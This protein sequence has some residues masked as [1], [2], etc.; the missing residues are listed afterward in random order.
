M[1][2]TGQKILLIDPETARI[3]SL[4]DVLNGSPLPGLRITTCLNLQD[5]RARLQEQS[6]A[7]IIVRFPV[8]DDS[9]AE[10]AELSALLALHESKPVIGLMEQSDTAGVFAALRLGIADLFVVSQVVSEQQAFIRS[11]TR[12]LAQARMIEENRFYRE[13][14]AQ[15]LSELK[16]DQQ[17]AYHVQRSMMPAE[18]IEVC[19][20]KARYLLMPSLYLSGDFVDV[21][22]VDE[23]RAVFYLADVSG[24]G[25]SSALVT[26]LLKNIARSMV[27][28]Y[29]LNPDTGPD[30]LTD[31]LERINK[32]LLET[33]VGKHLSI[34]IG[35]IDTEKLR[36]SYAVGGHH[37][38]PL[39]TDSA[40][41]RFLE[42]RGMPVGLFEKPV[43][44]ERTIELEPGFQVTLF[45]D[46]ILEVLPQKNM[47]SREEY[48]RGVVNNLRGATPE[49]LRDVLLSGFQS[50]VPD[51][52][53]VMTI[54]GL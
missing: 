37:P 46:G 8:N 40:G 50:E 20:I 16:A 2:R 5:A 51:D 26:M 43:Y 21:V 31:V 15:S 30:S 27:R 14:L 39:L 12:L 33:G 45:S 28:D 34:F 11:V 13:E 23:H 4:F 36:L 53:A 6:F 44:D 48:V 41:T 49:K 32:E 18:L 52:I 3:D 1:G 54:V 22:P 10:K 29:K 17:A 19:G 47:I 25:T 9:G 7:L 35:V 24:H 42:G 38:M